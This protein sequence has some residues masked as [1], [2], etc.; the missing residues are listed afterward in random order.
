MHGAFGYETSIDLS[1]VSTWSGVNVDFF[2]CL[3][4]HGTL[5]RESSSEVSTASSALELAPNW[6]AHDIDLSSASL[7]ESAKPFIASLFPFVTSF[8][9]IGL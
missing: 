8:N 1:E 2:E 9:P 6:R 5:E 3:C 7:L 4:I